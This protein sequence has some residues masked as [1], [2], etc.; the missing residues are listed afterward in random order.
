MAM[1]AGTVWK[2]FVMG[3]RRSR[4]RHF[5]IADADKEITVMDSWLLQLR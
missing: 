3:H 5:H 2:A 4:Y 1:A